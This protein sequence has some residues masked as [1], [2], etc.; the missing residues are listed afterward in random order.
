M[1]RAGPRL[2][3]RGRNEKL[4]ALDDLEVETDQTL[5]QLDAQLAAAQLT[6]QEAAIIK[7]MR[8]RQLLAEPGAGVY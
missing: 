6:P 1:T 8:D 2:R 4:K 7:A 3:R 5:D